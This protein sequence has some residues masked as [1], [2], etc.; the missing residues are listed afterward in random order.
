MHKLHKSDHIVSIL[1]KT[2]KNAHISSTNSYNRGLSSHV[3]VHKYAYITRFININTWMFL[4]RGLSSHCRITGSSYTHQLHY[5]IVHRAYALY[6][7]KH[8][9]IENNKL[10]LLLLFV[11]FAGL[12]SSVVLFSGA[13]CRSVKWQH[14]IFFQ[15]WSKPF[16]GPFSLLLGWRMKLGRNWLVLIG[17]ASW[18]AHVHV[19]KLNLD[20]ITTGR[21]TISNV[22]C[23]LF[24][25][26]ELELPCFSF[27][28]LV[29]SML[30]LWWQKVGN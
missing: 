29:I 23:Y 1:K 27:F 9:Y 22:A 28:L 19:S 14:R 6:I 8:I 3:Q 4:C 20:V 15:V 25:A 12:A 11:L 10:N 24:D 2:K 21:T 16:V 26:L 17:A 30:W 5:I 13:H 18:P 7:T